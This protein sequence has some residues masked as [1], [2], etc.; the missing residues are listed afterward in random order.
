MIAGQERFQ[1]VQRTADGQRFVTPGGEVVQAPAG[2][3]LVPAS[4]P[5][6]RRLLAAGP[7]LCVLYTAGRSSFTTGVLVP[8]VRLGAP[9]HTAAGDAARERL[10]EL[11][12]FAPRHAHVA[13]ELAQAIASRMAPGLAA[14]GRT[15]SRADLETALL[16]WLQQHVESEDQPRR[17][18]PRSIQRMRSRA[19]AILDEYRI[20]LPRDPAHCPL[21]RAL[22]PGAERS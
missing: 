2:W 6:C 18:S 12:D 17:S 21:V 13:R 10:I 20:G 9:D 11:L 15:L 16:Q 22:A 7:A 19:L 1:V 14:G 5:A 3:V 8:P 4:D